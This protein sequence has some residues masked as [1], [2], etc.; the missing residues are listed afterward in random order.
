MLGFSFGICA[1][2]IHWA[3]FGC[4]RATAVL[5]PRSGINYSDSSCIHAF[6]RF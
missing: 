1:D 3:N 2:V 5:V 4:C 6:G